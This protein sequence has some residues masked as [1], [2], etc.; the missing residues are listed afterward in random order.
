M[1]CKSKDISLITVY[2]YLVWA[3]YSDGNM[4]WSRGF[5]MNKT[6]QNTGHQRP[7]GIILCIARTTLKGNIK[8]YLSFD[9]QSITF[10][11]RELTELGNTL[12]TDDIPTMVILSVRDQDLEKQRNKR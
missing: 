9:A 12:P 5:Q 1:F 2:F 7:V 8:V 4:R 3:I 6:L 11:P 10:Y